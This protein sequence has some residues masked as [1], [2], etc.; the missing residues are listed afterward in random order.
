MLA[1]NIKLLFKLWYRPVSAMSEIIDKGDWLFGATLVTATAFLFA[2]TV[3]IRIYK[4]YESVPIAPDDR[5]V[6]IEPPETS[7]SS[8]SSEPG[9]AD[10]P[11]QTESD[12]EADED[13][14][15][16]LPKIQRAPLP[17]IGNAGWRL[18][19]FNPTSVFAIAFSLAALYAPAAILALTLISRTG[20]FS[21]AFR[22]DY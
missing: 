7:P 12:R 21:V 13:V 6:T 16:S 9:A 18:V 22:R 20:S 11:P 19:S 10:Q 8:T 3:S 14:K 15:Q 2:F 17:V 5:Q 1:E 4:G